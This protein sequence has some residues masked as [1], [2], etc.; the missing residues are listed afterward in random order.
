MTDYCLALLLCTAHCFKGCYSDR[1]LENTKLQDNNQESRPIT[2]EL[3]LSTVT[4][5]D[6]K[7][8]PVSS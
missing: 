5:C 2:I 7:P 1:N 3:N 6:G 8:L 4:V